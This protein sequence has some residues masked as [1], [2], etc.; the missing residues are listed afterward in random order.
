M[1]TGGPKVGIDHDQTGRTLAVM[2]LGRPAPRL[3]LS[4]R[5][6][7]WVTH[8]PAELALFPDVHSLGMA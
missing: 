6:L 1:P 2:A 3:A 5:S 8:R 7:P 4:D